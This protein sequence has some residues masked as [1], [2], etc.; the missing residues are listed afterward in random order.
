MGAKDE[1]RL[2]LG[3]G[4][5]VIEW[6]SLCKAE[7]RVEGWVNK[8]PDFNMDTAAQHQLFLLKAWPR[9]FHNLF[10]IVT[11][12]MKDLKKVVISTQTEMSF[13]YIMAKIKY[14]IVTS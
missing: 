14:K 1:V 9:S 2:G 6:Q 12:M 4:L 8:S 3:L 10:I 7:V 5:G 13:H 11:I